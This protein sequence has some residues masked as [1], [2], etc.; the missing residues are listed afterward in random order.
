MQASGLLC[1]GVSVCFVFH[2]FSFIHSTRSRFPH[3]PFH[4]DRLSARHSIDGTSP[5]FQTILM[6]LHVNIISHSHTLAFKH[7]ASGRRRRRH[8]H[9]Q[10]YFS[11]IQQGTERHTSHHRYTFLKH[12]RFLWAEFFSRRALLWHSTLGIE[13][14][15][16]YFSNGRRSI[17]FL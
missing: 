5:I 3:Q 9:P 4:L 13:A 7:Y 10:R 14:V 12:H 1:V 6:L 11:N 2:S 17:H 16:M 15:I 8:R